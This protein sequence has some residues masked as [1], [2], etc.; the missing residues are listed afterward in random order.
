MTLLKPRAVSHTAVDK[1]YIDEQDL[2]S[3]EIDLLL[4]GIERRYGYDFRDYSQPM[5]RRRVRQAVGNEGVA[6]VS[7]LQHR[8]LH[9]PIALSRFVES[10]SV[11]VSSMFRD[12]AFYLALRKYAVPILRTYP[13]IRVWHAGC[14]TGEEVYSLAIL[15]KEEGLYDR[16]RIYATDMSEKVLSRARA[17]VFSVENMKQFAVNYQ[18]SG[19]KGRF[20]EYYVSDGENGIFRETLKRNLFF[21]EHNLVCDGPFNVFHLI[22]CRNVLIYFNQTLRG[23][24]LELL[25][26]S[27]IR[28]GLLG[29]G[30]KESLEYSPLGAKYEELGA[31]TR[32]YRVNI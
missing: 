12:P 14:A 31:D 22:L 30:L 16:A 18:L 10:L 17:G 11:H 19:G 13:F 5:L 3:I 6:S 29:L 8:V 21:S 28:F 7:E 20:D 32:L 27:L 24:V 26:S 23:H 25:H 4:T 1:K 9:D 2:E 15:L